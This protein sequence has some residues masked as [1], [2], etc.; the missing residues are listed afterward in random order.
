MRNVVGSHNLFARLPFGRGGFG[1]TTSTMRAPFAA[2]AV[3]AWFVELVADDAEQDLTPLKLQKLVYLAHSLYMHRFRVPLIEDEVQAW[4]DGPVVKQVYGVY[5]SFQNSPIVLADQNLV[6]R[7]W[8]AEAEETLSDIWACFGGYSALKLRSITH[9]AGPWKQVWTP[10]SRNL[11][12]P[13][14]AIRDA[15]VQFE[16]YAESPLVART[17]TTTAALARYSTLLKDLPTQKREG[18]VALL[19]EESTETEH[20]RRRASSQ[21]E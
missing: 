14:D 8:P 5:K 9:E 1:L 10:D 12:I 20:L 19:E 11:I 17:N 13:A 3:A 4:K 16:K 2:T 7:S 18:N 21:L 15:W 6:P